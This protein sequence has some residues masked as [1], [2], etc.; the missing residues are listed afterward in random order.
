MLAGYIMGLAI[1]AFVGS[2]LT[3]GLLHWLGKK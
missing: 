2:W 1:G 3:I